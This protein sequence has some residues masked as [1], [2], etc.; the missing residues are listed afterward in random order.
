M[1]SLYFTG[2]AMTP[3]TTWITKPRRPYESFKHAKYSEYH[4]HCTDLLYFPPLECVKLTGQKFLFCLLLYVRYLKECLTQ[5]S[6]EYLLHKWQELKMT[7]C[8]FSR[9]CT[10]LE[11]DFLSILV[12]F[13]LTDGR[14]HW[15]IHERLNLQNPEITLYMVLGSII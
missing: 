15:R 11:Y 3:G 8:N 13:G 10:W 5:V 2:L 6:I 9:E 4:T 14:K 1:Y 7:I 12:N